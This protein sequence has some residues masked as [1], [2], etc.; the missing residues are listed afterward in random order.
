MAVPGRYRVR[1][2]ADGETQTREFEIRPDPRLREVNPADLS[3]R[4]ELALRIRDEVS[5]ATGAV[6]GIRALQREV[7]DRMKQTDRRDLRAAGT[8]LL[9]QLSGVEGEIYQ[10]ENRTVEDSKNHPMKLVN[11]IGYL[12]SVVESAEAR[13]T[14]QTRAVFDLLSSRLAAQLRRLDQVYRIELVRLNDLLRRNRLQPV[15]AGHRT[16]EG[17]TP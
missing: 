5:K 10:V 4:F 8:A 7:Q 2:T 13:P 16:K 11:Q 12:L 15:E 6:V 3:Q 14:D 17:A 9:A 1:L